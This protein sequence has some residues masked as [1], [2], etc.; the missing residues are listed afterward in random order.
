MFKVPENHRIQTGL[1]GSKPNSGNNGAFKFNYKG[2]DISVIASDKC[3][4]EHVSVTINRKRTPSWEI[5]C[6]VKN[7][8]WDEDDVVIQFHPPKS[9]YV[10]NHEF[11]LHL[12][13]QIG[14]IQCLP[15]SILVG[16][17]EKI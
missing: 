13:R 4:W 15:D 3:G 5:M 9:Q 6:Y 14:V 2:Y 17:K 10:N 11:C 12:W 8:F 1:F 16:L 7:L